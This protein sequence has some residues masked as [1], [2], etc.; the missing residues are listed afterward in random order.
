MS[1]NDVIAS[2]VKNQDGQLDTEVGQDEGT[3]QEESSTQDW[4]AQ[5]KYHQ[6]EKDKLHTENQQLKL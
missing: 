3:I 2:V 5:A 4:E 1:D 6:S